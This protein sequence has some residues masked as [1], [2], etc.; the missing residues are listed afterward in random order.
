M[1]ATNNTVSRAIAIHAEATIRVEQAT[2]ARLA[3]VTEEEA[4]TANLNELERG[5]SPLLAKHPKQVQGIERTKA[6]LAKL[7]ARLAEQEAALVATE[8]AIAAFYGIATDEPEV[9]PMTSAAQVTAVADEPVTVVEAVE[10]APVVA[11]PTNYVEVDGTKYG[12]DE[13][14][15]ALLKEVEGFKGKSQGTLEPLDGVP[16]AT[17]VAVVEEATGPQLDW[18]N[19]WT[20]TVVLKARK[21]PL[22]FTIDRDGAGRLMFEPVSQD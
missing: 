19:V 17:V 10:E 8:D 16:C 18:T 14:G 21:N 9:L 5:G 6:A 12:I 20:F 15:V 13:D 4:A 2:A 22:R 1:T 11:V 3:A 7:A